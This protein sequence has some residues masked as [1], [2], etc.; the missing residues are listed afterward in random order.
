MWR[1]VWAA[2]ALAGVLAPRAS[3]AADPVCTA[4]GCYAMVSTPGNFSTQLQACRSMYGGSP[5]SGARGWTLAYFSDEDEWADVDDDCGGTNSGNSG[6]EFWVGA[7][8]GIGAPMGSMANNLRAPNLTDTSYIGWAFANGVSNA[9]LVAPSNQES[10]M[11]A[12]GEPQNSDRDDNCVLK[13]AGGLKDTRCDDMKPACC[14]A[15]ATPT[16]APSRSASAS[17]SPSTSPSTSLSGSLTPS[18]TLSG[19]LSPS[20]T[21]SSSPSVS[22]AVTPTPSVTAS[23]TSAIEREAAQAQGL[24]EPQQLG[25]GLGIGIGIPVLAGCFACCFFCAAGWR[26]RRS[27]KDDKSPPNVVV[28]VQPA[29]PLQPPPASSQV[30]PAATAGV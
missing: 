30:T 18:A 29:D 13:A 23:R 15:S 8:D 7:Y 2:A 11:W 19:S 17:A 4:T 28:V 9:W 14:K 12:P 10:G 3:G 16:P 27:K 22:A 25:L 5:T 1:R 20:T 24:S 21:L 6:E 26:R